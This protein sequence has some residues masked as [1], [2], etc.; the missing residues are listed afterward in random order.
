MSSEGIPQIALVLGSCTAGGAYMPAMAG[1]S[2]MVKGKGT[3][4]LA[5]PPLV[6]A[7]TGEEVTSEDLEGVV[8]CKKSG[9]FLAQDA[10]SN[11]SYSNQSLSIS[12]LAFS[13]LNSFRSILMATEEPIVLTEPTE[14]VDV[15]PEEKPQVPADEKSKKATKAK[16]A[17]AKAKPRSPSLHPPYFEMIKEAIVTLKER[18]GSSQYAISKFVEEKHKNLPANFKKV[19]LTQ[20]KKF[21]TAGKLVKVK[22]SYKLPAATAPAKKKPAAKPKT[23]AK[24]KSV[25][26]KAPAKKAPVAKPKPAPKAK[27]AAKPKAVAKPKPAAKAKPAAK[28]KSVTK[29]AA[30]AKS[31]A[32]PKAVSAKAKPAA[33]KAP[34]KPSKVARTST[35]STPGKKAPEAAKPAAKKA[36]VKKA[37][38]K[39]L[40]PKPAIAKKVGKK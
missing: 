7:A 28:P 6:K 17:P 35:R 26:K 11:Y 23:V 19:L 22:A 5:W 20:L 33:K 13:D 21:V 34:A 3:L 9:V 18:T 8:H 30:K 36:A 25:K 38:A 2:V 40:K 32:K 31:V 14:P 16:K 4:F 29:P 12:S 1:E 15:A 27:P 39:S 10:K 37:T 24:P